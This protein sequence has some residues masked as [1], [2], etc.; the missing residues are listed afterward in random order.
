[1]YKLLKHKA[2]IVKDEQLYQF[3][4]GGKDDEKFEMYVCADKTT[5]ENLVSRTKELIGTR[6]YGGLS[7][8]EI[9][10]RLFDVYDIKYRMKQEPILVRF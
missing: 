8:Q 9:L 3:Y 4:W 2:N 1:M 6:Q 10:E 5:V 7:D